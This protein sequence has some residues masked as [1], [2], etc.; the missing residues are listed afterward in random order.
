MGR[1]SKKNTCSVLFKYIKIMENEERQDFF[2]NWRKQRNMISNS[3]D[4][5][6]DPQQVKYIDRKIDEIQIIM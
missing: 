6:F 4:L 1:N 2:T 3:M 5:R